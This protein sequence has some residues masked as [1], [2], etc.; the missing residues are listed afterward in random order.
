M[1]LQF[2]TF[3]QSYWNDSGRYQKEYTFLY[4]H[5]NLGTET[6]TTVHGK[7]I[8]IFATL[9][10][11]YYVHQN[12]NASEM[13][14]IDKGDVCSLCRGTGFTNQATGDLCTTCHGSGYHIDILDSNLRRIKPHF[15]YM[16][17]FLDTTL[18][19]GIEVIE[20]IRKQIVQPYQTFSLMESAKYTLLGDLILQH[21]LTTDDVDLKMLQES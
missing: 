19:N 17:R 9:L 16:L 7:L 15:E 21:I 1:E 10:K 20:A 13:E 5:F 12:E 6:P 18:E 11:E 3:D 14:T 2:S 4:D 8:K